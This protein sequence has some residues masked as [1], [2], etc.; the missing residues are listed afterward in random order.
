M[1]KVVQAWLIGTLS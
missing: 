1:E